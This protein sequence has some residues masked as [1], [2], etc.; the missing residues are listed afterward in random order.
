MTCI[1]LHIVLSRRIKPVFMHS[2]FNNINE[3]AIK[4]AGLTT[5]VLSRRPV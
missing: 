1:N 5:L 3:V 4:G 2:I